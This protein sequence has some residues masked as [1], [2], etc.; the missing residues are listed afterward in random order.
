MVKL[1]GKVRVAPGLEIKPRLIRAN[2]VATSRIESSR[3]ENENKKQFEFLH[4]PPSPAVVD[5]NRYCRPW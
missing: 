2:P 3:H 5:S 4:F 1:V